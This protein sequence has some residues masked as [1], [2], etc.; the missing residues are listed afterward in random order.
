MARAEWN[1]PAPET[2]PTLDSPFRN[3]LWLPAERPAR[4]TP[5]TGAT[6]TPQID[7]SGLAP[8]SPLPVSEEAPPPAETPPPP[9]APETV[10]PAPVEDP[11]QEEAPAEGATEAPGG[12]KSK[13]KAAEPKAGE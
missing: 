3:Q 7:L 2:T 10:P 4:S 11:P 8:T 6:R 5:V 12:K 1:P 13:K 9:A